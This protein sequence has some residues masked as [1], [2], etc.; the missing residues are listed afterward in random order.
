MR[1]AIGIEP[2]ADPSVMDAIVENEENEELPNIEGPHI[3][4]TATED[5]VDESEGVPNNDFC[6]THDDFIEYQSSMNDATRH[7]NKHTV[8]WSEIKEMEGEEVSVSSSV[9]GTIKWKVVES[10][11][12]DDMTTVIE[13]EWKSYKDGMSVIKS[14]YTSM[15]AA[16]WDAWP[17]ELETDRQSINDIIAI[18]N[19][20]RKERYQRVIKMVTMRELKIFH[21]LLIGAT[22]YGMKGTELWANKS[23]GQ[24]RKRTLSETVD[25]SKYM[26]EWR[27]KEIKQYIPEVMQDE[28]MKVSDDWWRFK[29]RLEMLNAKMA[30]I[31]HVSSVLV[32][33]ESMSAFIPRYALLIL[34][35]FHTD[36][37][38]T[39]SSFCHLK[40]NDKDWYAPKY[41]I[42][43][44]QT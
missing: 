8:A 7:Q 4:A 43:Q 21:G 17:T 12:A 3:N 2:Q 36:V 39:S 14:E 26:K 44:T 35:V 11:Q 13:K 24:K 41:I 28:S 40:Q 32:F 30:K 42:C 38:L 19:I 29:R 18:E 31:Y 9:Q 16:F 20:A 6:F 37:L 25:Y 33:D 22:A 15:A 10:V 27:F 23:G 5:P 1:S 34:F